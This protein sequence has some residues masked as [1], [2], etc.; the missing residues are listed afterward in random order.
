MIEY[1]LCSNNLCYV[2]FGFD[3]LVGCGI[4]LSV[5]IV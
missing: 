2:V 1:L 5:V 4:F 3:G